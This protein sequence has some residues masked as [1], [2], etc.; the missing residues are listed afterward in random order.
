MRR[1]LVTCFTAF[2]G[3]AGWIGASGA[4]QLLP[5]NFSVA[6]P[7]TPAREVAPDLLLKAATFVVM[8]NL[9]QH[10]NLE[11]S[12][13]KEFAELVES[14]LLPLFD[15][16]HM[17]RLAVARNWRLATPEQ[18]DALVAGFSTLLVHTYSTVLTNYQDQAIDY[19]PLR[20]APGVSEVTVK[21][22]IRQHGTERMTIDYDMEKTTT[23]WKIYD[24]RIAD[25]SLI[26]AYRPPFAKTV[27]DRGV[28]GLIESLAARNRQAESAPKTH[29]SGAS[30]LILMYSVIQNFFRGDR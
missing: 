3:L 18:R 27:R 10:R 28:D 7:A 23:G 12:N 30:Y 8:T 21:S 13:P 15:F 22:V 29:E 6:G 19:K 25:I 11:T 4:G 16:H 24:I 17:T 1:M 14:T 2:V 5:A 20:I 26:S 9:Q